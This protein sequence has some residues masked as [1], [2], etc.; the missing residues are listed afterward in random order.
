MWRRRGLKEGVFQLSPDTNPALAVSVLAYMTP[1][2]TLARTEMVRRWGGFYDHEKCLFAEDA[3][4]WLKVLLNEKI[5][6]SF[7]PLVKIHGEASDLSRNLR[8]A[9]PVEPFLIEPEEIRGACPP[10]LRDLLDRILAIRAAKTAC[11]LGYW[12]EWRNARLLMH[13]FTNSRYWQLPYYGPALV[14][15]TPAG[16]VLGKTWRGLNTIFGN[17][18]T[19]ASKVG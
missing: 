19:Q 2:T 9:R 15:S 13:R 7:K 5:A 18:K 17:N 10:A 8:Q 6:I 12:G 11:V 3:F 14:C 1:P 4:L 16:A